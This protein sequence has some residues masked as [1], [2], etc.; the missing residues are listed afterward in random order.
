MG[1]RVISVS[2]GEPFLYPELPELLAHARS[3]GL[4]TTVITNGFFLQPRWLQPVQGLIDVLAIS[5]DGPPEMHNRMRRSPDAF[6]RVSAGLETLRA[7]QMPFGI[8]HTVTSES[9]DHLL[10][11]A[12][13]AAS[14]GASLLQL[15][16][17]EMAG[18]AERELQSDAPEADVLSHTYLLTFVL[19]AQYQ[20]QMSIHCDLLHSEYIQANPELIYAGNH[21]AGNHPEPVSAS[22]ATPASLL[23]LIVLEADGAIVPASYGFS[24]NYQL[25]NIHQQRLASVWPAFLEQTYPRFRNLCRELYDDILTGQS[26]AL[27]NWHDTIVTRSHNHLRGLEL[28]SLEVN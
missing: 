23:S 25:C 18:R 15:H 11:L 6:D 19:A 13:F 5:L 12:D 27:F 9:L 14:N 2:G 21:Y 1:Y 17:L 28:V 22:T 7:L 24:R 4:S 26:P 10:W 8:I 16:P 20:G 3:L